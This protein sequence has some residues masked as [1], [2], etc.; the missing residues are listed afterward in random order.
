MIAILQR[1][2][3]S[4]VVVDGNIIGEIGNGLNILLGVAN[5]DEKSDSD[6]LTKKISKFR[7]F[8]DKNR[9]MNLS[10]QDVKGSALVISQFTLCADVKRGNRPGFSYTAKPEIAIELYEYFMQKLKNYDIHVESGSFGAMMDVHLIN[11]GPVTFVLNSKE[12]R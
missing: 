7:I 3:K 1:V 10:I 12:N 2:K 8:P 4:K 5:D 9:N 6:F 11:D